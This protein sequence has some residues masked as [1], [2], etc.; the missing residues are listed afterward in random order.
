M[1]CFLQGSAPCSKLEQQPE[2]KLPLEP[3]PLQQASS[4]PE[5]SKGASPEREEPSQAASEP[6]PQERQ[7]SSIL[8]PTPQRIGTPTVQLITVV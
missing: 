5:L 7:S 3:Q 8:R 4:V 1:Q 2:P 6:G